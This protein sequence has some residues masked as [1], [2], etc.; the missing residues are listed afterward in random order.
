MR[1]RATDDSGRI[2]KRL[3]PLAVVAMLASQPACYGSYG[4]FNKVHKWNGT[5]SGNKIANSAIH[6]GF[7]IL[8]VYPLCL[9][10]DFLI[11]NNVE[12]ITGTPVFK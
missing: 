3:A 6:L 5:A 4:A 10:G 12:F 1:R 2:M 11:F 9:V 8:P 7:W